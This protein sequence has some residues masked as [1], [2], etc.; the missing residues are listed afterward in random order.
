[1]EAIKKNENE[2]IKTSL[3]CIEPYENLW[4]EK[5]NLDILREPLEKTKLNWSEELGENDIF[6]R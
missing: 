1:M 4:L 2:N 6:F 5:F 3:K